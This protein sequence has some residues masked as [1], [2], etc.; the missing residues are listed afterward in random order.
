MSKTRRNPRFESGYGERV[1]RRRVAAIGA[2]TGL[3]EE[4]LDAVASVAS[5]LEFAAGDAVITEGDFGHSLFLI[6]DGSAD[7]SIDGTTVHACG[8]GEVLGAPPACSARGAPRVDIGRVT[9]PRGMSHVRPRRAH[10]NRTGF[11][12]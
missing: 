4:E 3:S 6:E 9:S 12:L 5:E 11:V 7:V 2:L 10:R 8:P 1:D